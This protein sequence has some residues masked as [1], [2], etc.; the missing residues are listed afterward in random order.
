MVALACILHH[1]LSL[2]I[3]EIFSKA[4]ALHDICDQIHAVNMPCLSYDIKPE[5]GLWVLM[6]AVIAQFGGTVLVEH[7]LHRKPSQLSQF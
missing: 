1:Y 4:G 6:A 7:V 2:Y 3:N 5:A